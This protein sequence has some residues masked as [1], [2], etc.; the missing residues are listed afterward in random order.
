MA[1]LT[2]RGKAS[3]RRVHSG[4][5]VLPDLKVE[6]KAEFVFEF[7]LDLRSTEQGTEAKTE[8]LKAPHRSGPHNGRDRGGQPL[9]AGG[10]AFQLRATRPGQ[11]IVFGA[12]VVVA[13]APFGRNPAL[14]FE[15]VEGRIQ[16]ALL[17]LQDFVG[18]LPDALCDGP[19]VPGSKRKGFE[20]QQIE[21][22]LNE[23]GGLAPRLSTTDYIDSCR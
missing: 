9:P 5:Q 13:L 4:V 1:E 21:G 20:D 12:A 7:A 3:L 19:A 6:V 17:D 8:Y 11:R 23:V 15:A 14:L 16:R 18:H 22:A 2:D 10:F